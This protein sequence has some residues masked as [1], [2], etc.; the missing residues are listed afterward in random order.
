MPVVVGVAELSSAVGSARAV[1]MSFV[2]RLL[3]LRKCNCNCKWSRWSPLWFER[4][5][6][7]GRPTG[8]RAGHF[9]SNLNLKSKAHLTLVAV[10]HP[11][12]I[13]RVCGGDGGHLLGCCDSRVECC[14]R[15]VSHSSPESQGEAQERTV[16][17]RSTRAST[18]VCSLCAKVKRGHAERCRS[19]ATS[20]RHRW[21]WPKRTVRAA[22]RRD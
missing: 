10:L 8:M 5:A 14:S 19:R 11:Q 18:S 21:I 15:E 3:R 2:A 1:P 9:G 4:S 7:P 6:P 17:I 12:K 20:V 22:A 13:I 16:Y